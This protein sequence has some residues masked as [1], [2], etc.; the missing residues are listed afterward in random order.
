MPKLEVGAQR[1][2]LTGFT[3]AQKTQKRRPLGR[4][5]NDAGQTM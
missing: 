5:A 4:P 3:M 1:K 2:L